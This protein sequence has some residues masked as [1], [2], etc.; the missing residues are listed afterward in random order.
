MRLRPGRIARIEAQA[1]AEPTVET[2][3][4]IIVIERPCYRPSLQQSFP[5]EAVLLN[6]SEQKPRGL[7]MY[8]C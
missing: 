3:L 4:Y 5:P 6:G 2:P 1:V 7:C 8:M